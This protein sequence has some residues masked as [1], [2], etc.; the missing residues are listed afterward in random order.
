[1]TGQTRSVMNRYDRIP[2]N[3]DLVRMNP[4]DRS[5]PNPVRPC[6]IQFFHCPQDDIVMLQSQPLCPLQGFAPGTN[7]GYLLVQR[8][9]GCIMSAHACFHRVT[10]PPHPRTENPFSIPKQLQTTNLCHGF[11]NFPQIRFCPTDSSPR[12]RFFFG[13]RDTGIC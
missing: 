2:A 5:D 12:T 1:M 11:S 4:H 3:R 6:C 7:P 10:S 8:T 13:L 9:R